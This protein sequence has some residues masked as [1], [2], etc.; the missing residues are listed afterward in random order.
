MYYI[1]IFKT[2]KKIQSM[3]KLPKIIL[4]AIGIFLLYYS[5]IHNPDC[6]QQYGIFTTGLL[7]YMG[8]AVALLSPF[9]PSGGPKILEKFLVKHPRRI[10]LSSITGTIAVFLLITLVTILFCAAGL[11][12]FHTTKQEVSL[13][14]F[15]MMLSAC[16]GIGFVLSIAMIAVILANKDANGTTQVHLPFTDTYYQ[17]GEPRTENK[18]PTSSS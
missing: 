6:I 17:F 8:V 7:L 15:A 3:K 18:I 4:F 5:F 1:V 9:Y 2:N 14:F 13:D 12:Y 16:L 11:M 10:T